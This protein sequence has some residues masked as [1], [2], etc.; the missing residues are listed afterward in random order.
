[1]FGQERL[2]NYTDIDLSFMYEYVRQRYNF[3]D[4]QDVTAFGATLRF[5]LHIGIV[6]KMHLGSPQIR[7]FLR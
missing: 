3:T 6:C 7:D 1:V 2:E 4:Y 5:S